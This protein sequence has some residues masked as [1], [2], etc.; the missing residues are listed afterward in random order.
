M[1][2][3]STFIVVAV[4]ALLA[5]AGVTL[6]ANLA[7]RGAPAL[8][9]ADPNIYDISIPMVNGYTDL[10]SIFDDINASGC[11][12]AEVAAFTPDGGSCVW[13]G[14]Y[15]CNRPYSPGEGVRVSVHSPCS[16][17]IIAGSN[18][19]GSPFTGGAGT[20]NFPTVDPD[21]YL[22]GAPWN[23]TAVTTADVFN[24]IPNADS[25]TYF[26]PDQSSCGWVG[27]LSC[28]VAIPAM[29]GFRVTVTAPTKWTP[30]VY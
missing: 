20:I 13:N 30:S 26:F 14:L 23:K 3:S 24:D 21:M 22:V 2:R 4:G 9:L 19:A 25:V 29:A 6:G 7:F 28:S 15:S 11:S 1:R 12:A 10:V 18:P 27:P 16:D 8:S 5:M 17:W